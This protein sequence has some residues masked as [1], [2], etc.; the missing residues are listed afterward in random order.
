VAAQVAARVAEVTVAVAV[1]ATAAAAAVKMNLEE[2]DDVGRI[3]KRDR[4]SRHA[5]RSELRKMAERRESSIRQIL[6]DR[7]AKKC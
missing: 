4:R 7:T 3:K 1:V 6:Q 2:V 5:L